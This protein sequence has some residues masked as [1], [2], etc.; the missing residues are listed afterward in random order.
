LKCWGPTTIVGHLNLEDET[1]MLSS[2][3]RNQLTSD[4]ASYPKRIETS[5]APLCTPK[6]SVIFYSVWQQM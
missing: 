6:N 1:P 4:V 2:N 3:A 5:A